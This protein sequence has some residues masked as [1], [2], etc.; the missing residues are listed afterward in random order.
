[1]NAGRAITAGMQ[2]Q[3]HKDWNKLAWSLNTDQRLAMQAWLMWRW[4][5]P[6]ARPAPAPTCG[7]TC[8]PQRGQVACSTSQAMSIP[9]G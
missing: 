4:A 5:I 2:A 9:P 1:M 3:R 8:N 6:V 7:D